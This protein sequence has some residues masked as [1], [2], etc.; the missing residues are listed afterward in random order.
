MPAIFVALR[1]RPPAYAWTQTT[2]ALAG[3]L[4]SVLAYGIVIWAMQRGAMGVVS[5]LRETS[6]VYAAVIGRLFLRERLTRRRLA[7]CV[8]IALGAACLAR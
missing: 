7:S 2:M 4:V 1:G 8:S 6:V 5:A 3:G